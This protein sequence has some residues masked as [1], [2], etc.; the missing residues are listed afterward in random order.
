M[1]LKELMTENFSLIRE[2]SSIEEARSKLSSDE[3]L[4]V[5][6]AEGMPLTVITIA[7]LPATDHGGLTE[8]IP[9]LPPTVIIG[10]DMNMSSIGKSPTRYLFRKSTRGAALLGERGVVGIVPAKVIRSY[11]K[12]EGSKGKVATPGRTGRLRRR[13]RALPRET[14]TFHV[15][16]QGA[17]GDTVRVMNVAAAGSL[18]GTRVVP[19]VP[20]KCAKCG[21]DDFYAYI[22]PTTN[23]KNPDKTVEPQPWPHTLG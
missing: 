10:C 21:W 12:Q 3:Y 16:G 14:I 1:L 11:L 2:S 13:R 8:C 17:I 9:K 18:G 19:A 5:T 22:L 20:R 6:N 7:D 15:S 4:V 23:C